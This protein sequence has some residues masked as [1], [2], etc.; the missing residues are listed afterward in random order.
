MM[1]LYMEMTLQ[2]LSCSCG[3]CGYELNLSSGDRNTSTIDSKY[4]KSI[5]KGIISFF[6]IYESRFTQMDEIQCIPHFSKHSLGLI[7]RRTKLLCRKCGNPIG[8]AYNDRSSHPIVSDGN[9]SSSD[10]SIPSISTLIMAESKRY[11][12]QE[13][14]RK[15]DHA[16]DLWI[17][18]QG[19]IYDVS[20]WLKDYPGGELPLLSLAG[21]D[22]TDAFVAYHPGTAWQYLHKFFFGYYLRDYYIS[23]ASKDY[24]KLV[25][26]FSK[27]GHLKR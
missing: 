7:C 10:L 18:I 16:G 11:I 27:M 19:K 4:G 9:D 3:S 17:S 1:V 24:K 26:K 23:K 12:S 5:K 13:E 22:A 25:S 20:V 2:S 6:Y 21:Q 14:L 8:I 15:H